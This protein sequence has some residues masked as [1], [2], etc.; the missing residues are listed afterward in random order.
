[1]GDPAA[2]AAVSVTTPAWQLPPVSSAH[3]SS[4]QRRR[5][6]KGDFA[7]RAAVDATTPVWQLPPVSPTRSVRQRSMENK[8]GQTPL[9]GLQT[10]RPL[11]PGNCHLAGQHIGMFM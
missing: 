11:Q 7:V 3:A 1:M 8:E 2:K 4:A 5:Q 9:P 6:G 10:A